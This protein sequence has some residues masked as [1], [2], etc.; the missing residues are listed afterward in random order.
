RVA[1]LSLILTMLDYIDPPDLQS[2]PSFKL[3]NLHGTNI[4]ESDFFDPESTWTAAAGK[5]TYDWIVGNPPWIQASSGSVADRHVL[6]WIEENSLHRPVGKKQVAEAFVWE[7]A[8]YATP[9]RGVI[10]LLLPAMILFKKEPQSKPGFRQRLFQSMWTLSVANFSNLRE[11]LFSR[12]AR[13]PA[14]ALFF[15]PRSTG[16]G[17]LR[18]ILVYSPL[19]VNQEANRPTGSERRKLIW[20][21]IP[22]ASEISSLEESEI[23]SGESLPWK[24]AMWGIGR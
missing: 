5:E 16:D 7:A 1:E 12:R 18:E 15:R 10:G 8:R 19:V 14:A 21:I 13:L 4:Y 6:R 9:D 2:T 20:S 22:N 17:R 3:P 11:V 23:N 24:L